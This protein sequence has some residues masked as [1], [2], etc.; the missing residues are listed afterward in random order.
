MHSG[1]LYIHPFDPDTIYHVPLQC[2][3]Q[4]YT[5]RYLT[6]TKAM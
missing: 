3:E 6:T 4:L 1:Q 2:A 5:L